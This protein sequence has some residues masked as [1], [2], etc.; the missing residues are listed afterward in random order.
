MTTPARSSASQ[1]GVCAWPDASSWSRYARAA[2][3]HGLGQRRGRGEVRDRHG[4]Q[5]E[6]GARG[7]RR[8]TQRE[9]R[10]LGGPGVDGQHDLAVVLDEP[11]G[12][13]AQPRRRAPAS[14]EDRPARRALQGLAGVAGRRVERVGDDAAGLGDARQQVVAVV[15]ADEGG[16][17][18]LVGEQEPVGVPTRDHLHGVPHVEQVRVR[19]VDRAVRPV[20]EPRR[21]ERGE[22]HGV[23]DAAARLLEL[24]LDEV[25]ELA[26]PVGPLLG[27][28]EQLG[29]PSPGGGTPVLEQ[30]GLGARDHHGVAGDGLQVEQPH[31]GGQVL[32]RHLAALRERAHRVV[33]VEP[34][35]PDRVPEPLRERRE[36]LGAV[37]AAL[38]HEQQVEVADRAR[39]AAADAADR[40][41]RHAAH[42][43]PCRRLLP[44][45]CEALHHQ[46]GDG[47]ASGDAVGLWA[48]ESGGEVEPLDTQVPHPDGVRDLRLLVPGRAP[49]GR[50][51]VRHPIRA[52]RR[53]A[54][55]CGREPRPPPARPR[56]CRHR[57]CRSAP[58]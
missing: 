57:S 54:R 7:G 39:V 23:A 24:G 3:G 13:R 20:G 51:F 12:D 11:L 10:V 36:L 27:R 14:D 38:V 8:G 42:V 47:A 22:H 16:D 53:R 33:E 37:P 45:L 1:I 41:E 15:E 34:G 9:Q 26:V 30:R 29:Q 32:G 58:P 55:R 2:L 56:P 52:R 17:L 21:G 46:R 19:A 40:A 44:E 31:R 4:R 5:H 28:G 49:H 43:A 50:P 18:V 25:G 35:V 48:G 6:P